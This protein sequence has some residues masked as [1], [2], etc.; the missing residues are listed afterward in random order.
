[1]DDKGAGSIDSM[2]NSVVEAIR[3]QLSTLV[4]GT[5]LA[6]AELRVVASHAGLLVG[7][8]VV[9]AGMALVLWALI[10]V[11]AALILISLGWSAILSVTGVIFLN[12]IFL[13]A[14][15]LYMRHIAKEISFKR[16]RKA[17]GFTEDTVSDTQ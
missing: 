6:W 4:T 11:L 9:V 12:L 5:Q 1:M 3:A 15:L 14:V 13:M 8:V 16:T 10:L 17:I 2:V 7:L